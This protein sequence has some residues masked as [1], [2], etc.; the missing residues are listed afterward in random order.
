[1]SSFQSL[2]R[3]FKRAPDALQ[4]SDYFQNMNDAFLKVA[5]EIFVDNKAS[6]EL[7]GFS[8][9]LNTT[10]SANNILHSFPSV[11]SRIGPIYRELRVY[12]ECLWQNILLTKYTSEN[13]QGRIANL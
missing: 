1:M 9:L 4:V 8:T 7:L 11:L 10:S 13:D 2:L 5:S 6:I 12:Y 3:F